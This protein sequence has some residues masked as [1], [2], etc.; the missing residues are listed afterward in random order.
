MI[1]R[2]STLQERADV[3]GAIERAITRREGTRLIT[4]RTVRNAATKQRVYAEVD[5][6]LALLRIAL[7]I[8]DSTPIEGTAKGGKR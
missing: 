4:R 2:F 8:I 5:R 6:D 7:A 3:A 1:H